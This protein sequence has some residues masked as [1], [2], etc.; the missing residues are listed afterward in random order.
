MVLALTTMFFYGIDIQVI[1]ELEGKDM[2]TVSWTQIITLPYDFFKLTILTIF[3]N[4]K[5]L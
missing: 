2:S 3:Y 1:S 4:V 5:F